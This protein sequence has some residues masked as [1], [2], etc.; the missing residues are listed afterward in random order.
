MKFICSQKNLSASINIVQKAVST[1]TTLP[2]LRG[3]LIEACDQKLKL[4][5]T[6]LEVGIEHYIDADILSEGSIV[7]SSRLLGDIIRKFPDA[8]VEVEVDETNTMTIKCANS[9]FTLIGQ[10]SVEFP[11]LPAVEEE[12]TYEI[13]QDLLKNM[14]RQTAFATA[15]DET[16]PILTGVLMEIQEGI[17]N[18]VAL[19]G[20]RLSLRQGNIKADFN[21]KAVIPGKTLNEIHRILSEEEN[22]KVDIF[23]TDKHVLFQMAN[24]RVISRLLE[25][26]FINYKQIIPK[27]F[28]S[29]VKVKTRDLLDSIE[30][31]SLLAREGKNNLIKF[32]VKD[33]MMTITSNAEIGRV[34]ENLRI[35][36]EGE[37]I[38]IGFNSKYFLDALK[39]LDSDE[40]YLD[41][42][43]NVS[44]CIIKPTDT[45]NYTYLVL[46]VRLVG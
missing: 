10:P 31:A 29:R 24:V 17:I 37:D 15:L 20:Y 36:L 23:F 1:K 26:E 33:E 39:I 32:S 46:P 35:E 40:I 7:I 11:E 19:D 9:E 3:I 21:N 25:G 22:A 6:D 16:R 13:P 12:N 44:P 38:D 30:R 8:D 2:I 14:I 45:N 28:K 42:T 18:M 27:D 5:G 4:V 34:Y 41:F 43:T